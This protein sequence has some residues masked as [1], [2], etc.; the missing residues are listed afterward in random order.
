MCGLVDEC[1]GEKCALICK[2][3]TKKIEEYVHI[4]GKLQAVG[5]ARQSLSYY[6]QQ[7]CTKGRNQ[8][9]STTTSN[10]NYRV[11]NPCLAFPGEH[12]STCISNVEQATVPGTRGKK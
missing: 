2:Y 10:N 1:P 4:C 12:P 7:E 6:K 9:Q 11:S 5:F 8:N 3:Y